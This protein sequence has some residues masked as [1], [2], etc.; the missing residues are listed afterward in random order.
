M[1]TA[2]IEPVFESVNSM[3]QESF[4]RWVT[5]REGWDPHDYELLHGRV[6]VV[7]PAHFPQGEVELTIGSFV[8][9]AARA[10]NG[11]A[12]GASQ[13]FEL[14]TG[15]TLAPDASWVS[16][17]RW[18]A[19]RPEPGKFLRLVPELAI[20]VLSP[21][22]AARDRGEKRGIYDT[23]GVGEYWLVDLVRKTITVYVREAD[24]FAEPRTYGSG[25][26]VTCTVLPALVVAVDDVCSY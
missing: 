6:V 24:R 21:S 2:E 20:E 18:A 16:A 25:E 5:R 13:G 14:P 8:R 22:T 7:P 19:A 3:D 11:R 12:F 4:A 17:E 9:A 23:A 15:D 26:T 1:S 10:T